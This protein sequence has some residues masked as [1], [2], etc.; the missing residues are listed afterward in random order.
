MTL[1]ISMKS[2]I[3]NIAN[4]AG[5]NYAKYSFDAIRGKARNSRRRSTPSGARRAASRVL[6][7]RESSLGKGLFAQTHP[8]N[9]SSVCKGPFVA[10]SC[11]A[12][13]RDLIESELF[14]CGR[15][16]RR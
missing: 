7:T 9:S 2:Q 4:H 8:H 1:S 14:V 13:P 6:L 12:I 15:G 16:F 10:V 11:A 3:I 5:G